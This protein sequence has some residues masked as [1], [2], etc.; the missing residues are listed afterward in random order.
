MPKLVGQILAFV[1][2]KN[3]FPQSK[4]AILNKIAFD[5]DYD[6]I[7][8]HKSPYKTHPGK[9]INRS[10]FDVC[11]LSS[12]GEYKTDRHKDRIVLYT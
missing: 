12:F 3:C 10:K 9:V 4:N 1:Y 11:M 7:M 5:F 2:A 6:V 8:S